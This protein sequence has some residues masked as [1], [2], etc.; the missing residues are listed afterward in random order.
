MRKTGV[1]LGIM[2]AVLFLFGC[3]K[4]NI[5]MQDSEADVEVE[6]TTAPDQLFVETND[7]QAETELEFHVELELYPDRYVIDAESVEAENGIYTI[8]GKK[9]Y[10]GDIVIRDSKKAILDAGVN[11]IVFYDGKEICSVYSKLHDVGYFYAVSYYLADGEP[12]LIQPFY[13]SRMDTVTPRPGEFKL[14]DLGSGEYYLCIEDEFEISVK[15]D[16]PIYP[17]HT[18]LREYWG[19]R[20]TEEDVEP[21]TMEAFYEMMTE[22]GYSL[23]CYY[24][25]YIEDGEVIKVE[26]EFCM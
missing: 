26:Q 17:Y 15:A 9:L 24:R 16:T 25:I 14:N 20:M 22:G 4:S 11:M 19:T 18:I 2:L 7:E 21:M 3:G 10:G 13:D 5:Q 23:N 6:E 8:C 12:V 1:V